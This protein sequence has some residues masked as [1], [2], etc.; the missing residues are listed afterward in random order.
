MII[1]LKDVDPTIFVF[2]QEYVANSIRDGRVFEDV[3]SVANDLANSMQE[4]IEDVIDF[5]TKSED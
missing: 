3:E 5:H 2:A 4:T 1:E